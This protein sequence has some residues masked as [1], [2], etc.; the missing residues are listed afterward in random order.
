MHLGPLVAIFFGYL[1]AHRVTWSQQKGCQV[2]DKRPS[3]QNEGAIGENGGYGERWQRT[4]KSAY[5]AAIS[6]GIVVYS[7]RRGAGCDLE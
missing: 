7:M 2:P 4:M 1:H 5:D 6:H 3:L